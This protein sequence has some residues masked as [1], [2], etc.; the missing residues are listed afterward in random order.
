VKESVG[1]WGRRRPR[2]HRRGCPGR[3]QRPLF[4]GHCHCCLLLCHGPPR[5]RP[6]LL[7]CHDGY[8]SVG[9]ATAVRVNNFYNMY[10][11]C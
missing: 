1:K 6:L 4:F 11:N 5:L 2:C 10:L 3:G 9:P 7:P 8:N